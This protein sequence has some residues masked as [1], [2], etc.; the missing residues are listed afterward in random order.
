MH[1]RRRAGLHRAIAAI[2]AGMWLSLVVAGAAL[3]SGPP[4]PDRPTDTHI[5]DDAGVFNRLPEEGVEEGLRAV[6]DSRG[7]DLVVYTQV[8]AAARDQ[9]AADADA[10]A[11]LEQWAVGGSDGQGAVLLWDFDKQTSR[12][13]VSLAL[14]DGLAQAVDGDAVRTQVTASM[15][16]SLGT[17]DWVNALNRGV[18]TLTTALPGSALA[19]PVATSPPAASV[20]PGATP[21]PLP[22]PRPTRGPVV[23]NLPSAAAGP[24]YP[25]PITGLRVYDYAGVLSGA[26]RQRAAATIAA[27]EARTGAQVVVYTQVKPDSD[28]PDLADADARALIDQYGVGRKG[29]DD[30]LAILF[31]LD[32]S[33]CHGQVQLTAGPGYR[34]SYLTNADRQAIYQDDMLPYLRRCD[35]SGAL[36]AALTRIDAATTAERARQLQLAR[37]IDAAT[38][39]IL[40]PLVLIALIAWAGWSWLRYGRDPVYIDDPSVLMPAPPPSLTPSAAAVILDGHVNRHA[41]TTAFVDLAGRGELRFREPVGSARPTLDVLDADRSDPRVL[42]NRNV[43]L[44]EPEAL[45]RDRLRAI[46]G[47]AGSLDAEELT[48]FAKA[49]PEF[50]RLLGSAVVTAGW[51]REDPEKST[52][53]WSFRAGLALVA[54]VV[55]GIIAWNLPSSGLLLL[56]GAVFAASIAMFVLARVM[57]QRTM[58]GAMVYAWLAA[59]RRTLERTLA[60]ARSMDDVVASH[61]LPW[62]ETPDQAVVWGYALGLH[63]EVEDVLE[64][65]VD[66]A[67]EAAASGLRPPYMPVWYVAGSP[68][69]GA[70]GGGG[71]MFSSSAIPDFG[72]MTAALSTI[73]VSASSS[74]SGGGGGGFGGGGSG[75][76]GGG[77]G[78]GF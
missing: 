15:A 63:H 5:V 18:F 2:A 21:A 55:G 54:G 42:R 71:G 59:Y 57:P 73:G 40:A 16:D 32:E 36:D 77:A 52:E 13:L 47:G 78:G 34:D 76:G 65:T 31:D 67:R 51:Y 35:M 45:V 39:L 14:S 20:A 27:I 44:G 19:T 48:G 68:G 58:S 12:A 24:P 26:A 75:G 49:I 41:L 11:L 72:S 28:T 17:D 22:T 33:K 1:G 25:A 6:L 70:G 7:V 43:P 50:D 61:A 38:G 53:R 64:R 30:G 10:Q 56:S 3:A 37:Q 66:T 8:K 62:V 60:G 74:S 9:A 46:R 69:S 4:F 29:F 23:P